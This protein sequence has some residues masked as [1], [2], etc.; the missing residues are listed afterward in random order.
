[1]KLGVRSVSMPGRATAVRKSRAPSSVSPSSSTNG[2][3]L[4]NGEREELMP[5]DHVTSGI[6]VI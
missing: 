2:G 3:V 4:A 1:M 5:L 6:S